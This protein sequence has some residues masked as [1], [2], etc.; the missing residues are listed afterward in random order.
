MVWLNN[1][2]IGH[3]SME[4]N[5]AFSGSDTEELFAKNLMLQ[6][7]DWYYRNNPIS[8]IRNKNGHRCNEIEDID[9]NNY[10]L[11][12]GC[13]H[14]EGIGIQ[15]E[16]SYPYL[17]SKRLKVDYYNLAV[18]GTGPDVVNYNIT[19]W[20]AKVK[21]PPKLI[22]VQWPHPTRVTV[23]NSEIWYNYG[24]WSTED[25]NIK[26]R[27]DIGN[28]FISGED[29]GFFKTSLFLTKKIISNMA[30]CPILHVGVGYSDVRCDDEYIL[31]QID[32]G[33]DIRNNIGHMG[34]K[35]DLLTSYMLYQK[36]IK[37]INT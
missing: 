1:D 21:K 12:T 28:F 2:F 19:T 14:T 18:G 6:P 13:S 8:Y 23:C 4:H 15:L 11:Y 9:L 10:I 16:N 5:V 29:I 20:F 7:D 33:R 37:L 22:V 31:R 26:N 35:S 24:P 34:I 3:H 25:K 36:A 30:P 17:L 32:S 27:N